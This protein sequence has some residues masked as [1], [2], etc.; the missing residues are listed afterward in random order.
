MDS[1]RNHGCIVNPW[2]IYYGDGEVF[3]NENGSVYDAPRVNVQV[4]AAYHQEYN[5]ELFSDSDY[6]YYDC[7][8]DVWFP[9]DQFGM[10]DVLIRTSKPLIF[11]G[12][13]IPTDDYKQIVTRVIDELPT[14]KTAWRRGQPPWLRGE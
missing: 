2:R 7:D 8:L 3:T 1:R 6:Y 11:F 5:W 13:Y 10:F 14:P 9:T 12:R 4:I